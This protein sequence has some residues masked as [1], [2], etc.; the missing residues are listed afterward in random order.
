VTLTVP[1]DSGANR[2]VIIA[3]D[4][5]DIPAQKVLYIHRRGGEKT[6]AAVPAPGPPRP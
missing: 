3:R 6:A 2:I 4:D 1:L 5:K